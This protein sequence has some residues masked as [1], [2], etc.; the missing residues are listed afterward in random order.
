MGAPSD[1]GSMTP[2][3]QARLA[4][5]EAVSRLEQQVRDAVWARTTAHIGEER[6]L[7]AAF[8]FFD[9]DASGNVDVDEF[10]KALESLGLHTE[11]AGLPGHGGLPVNVVEGLFARYDADSSGTVDYDE[12]CS[13]LLSDANTHKMT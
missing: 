4:L 5:A 13:A 12:F 8:A 9:K 2:E 11:K 1:S 6:V 3:V 7:K 10:G